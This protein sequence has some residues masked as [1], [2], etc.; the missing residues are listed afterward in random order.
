M[1]KK[2]A[3]KVKAPQ[4]VPQRLRDRNNGQRKSKPE[5]EDSEEESPSAEEKEDEGED[6]EDEDVDEPPKKK[7][8]TTHQSKRKPKPKPAPKVRPASP[9]DSS[10]DDVPLRPGPSDAEIKLAVRD[11]L[12]SKDLST[13]TKGMV[14]E[15]L[16]EKY[17]ETLVKSKKE[18]IAVGIEEGME[19]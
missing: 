16:R 17:G 4:K 5:G 11:F 18:V 19:I 8:K 6:G 9:I 7:A 14:K 13:V 2:S 3:D 10:D 1:K 15:A 12:K